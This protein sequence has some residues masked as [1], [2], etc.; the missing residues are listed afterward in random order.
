MVALL[1]G[2][3]FFVFGSIGRYEQTLIADQDNAIVYEEEIYHSY[4]SDMASIICALL[5]KIGL[6][7]CEGA[8]LANNPNWCKSIESW[9]NYFKHW[10]ATDDPNDLL[11]TTI[12]SDARHIYGNS[13]ITSDILDNVRNVYLSSPLISQCTLYLY[14]YKL[15]K[16]LS[17][18]IEK[19]TIDAN[20]HIIDI[21]QL[22]TQ[23]ADIIRLYSMKHNIHS[24][25]TAKR[26]IALYEKNIIPLSLTTRVLSAFNNII[27]IRLSTQA[28]RIT[29]NELPDNTLNMK[30][31][32]QKDIASLTEAM[33]AT[34]ELVHH[35]EQDFAL[36]T[37]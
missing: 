14:Q 5:N 7:Y 27:R 30:T 1:A 21:K 19:Y 20:K 6:I 13:S 11:Q 16:R 2:F 36:N 10:T 24:T 23:I 3:L 4:F 29:N 25:G 37:G 32:D 8:V 26:I 35:F 9:K 33:Q 22:T 12:F 28:R 31:L 18:I 34:I 15:P 17:E